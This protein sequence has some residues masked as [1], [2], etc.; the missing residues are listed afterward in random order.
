MN[1]Y[2][3]VMGLI[4][5]FGLGV[6]TST[7]QTKPAKKLPPVS[8]SPNV[9]SKVFISRP[10]PEGHMIARLQVA[11]RPNSGP[12]APVGPDDWYIDWDGV[13]YIIEPSR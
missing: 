7:Y 3:Y 13:V 8:L 6:V 12:D 9:G 4:I 1:R 11:N 5:A 2:Y 10:S